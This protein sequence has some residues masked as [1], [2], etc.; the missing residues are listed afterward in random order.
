MNYITERRSRTLSNIPY[1]ISYDDIQTMLRENLKDKMEC[2]KVT[3][4]SNRGESYYADD[5]KPGEGKFEIFRL[6]FYK[7]ILY[8][9]AKTSGF[10]SNIRM[11]L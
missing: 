4:S 2:E 9:D 3:Q 5:N 1:E 11:V 8:R 6:A 7:E 10:M